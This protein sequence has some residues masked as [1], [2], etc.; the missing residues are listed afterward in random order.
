MEAENARLKKLVAEAGRRCADGPHGAVGRHAYGRYGYR[1]ITALLRREG[2]WVNHTRVE[3]VWRQ[4]GMKVPAKQPKRGRIWLNDGSCVRLR[5][6]H[7]DHVW[8]YDFIH[9]RTRD[10]RPVRMLTVLDEVHP[11]VPGDPPRALAQL[12]G[13]SRG[14]R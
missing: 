13:R 9:D 14:T 3:R 4:Q 2:W 8:S 5:S 10:G 12:V 7:K 1:R 11:R 6:T